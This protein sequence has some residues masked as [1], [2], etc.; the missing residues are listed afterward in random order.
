MD[1]HEE[2][3]RRARQG[4]AAAAERLASSG[5]GD[6]L[7]ALVGKR[8][9]RRAATVTGVSA[10]C[11]A[12]AVGGFAIAGPWSPGPVEPAAVTST[13]TTVIDASTP[14]ADAPFSF[15]RYAE[16]APLA[17]GE[18][19]AVPSGATRQVDDASRW[20]LTVTASAAVTGSDAGAL[21]L[22]ED[23]LTWT[24]EVAP[25]DAVED[26]AF[27]A[28][29][30]VE[31]DGRVAASTPLG[32]QEPAGGG[33]LDQLDAPV[34]GL[35]GGI[36]AN[37][38]PDDGDYTFHLWVQ[39]VDAKGAP[40]ATV[41]DPVEP[42][43]LN[44]KGIADYWNKSTAFNGYPNLSVNPIRCGDPSSAEGRLWND[45]GYSADLP[46]GVS[47]PGWSASLDGGEA[48][49]VTNTLDAPLT[50]QESF[51]IAQAFGVVDGVVV[52]VGD[53]RATSDALNY[54]ASLDLSVPC[55]VSAPSSMDVYV[56]QEALIADGSYAP[57]VTAA[58]LF[59]LGPTDVVPAVDPAPT[60]TD[61]P[62]YLADTAPAYGDAWVAE[63]SFSVHS[64][65]AMGVIT[66]LSLEPAASGDGWDV[67]LA[68]P[69]QVGPDVGWLTASYAVA[70]G[71][72]VGVSDL[73]FWNG[74]GFDEGFIPAPDCSACAVGAAGAVTQHVVIQAVTL[75]DSDAPL[76]PL[77]T[78]VDPFGS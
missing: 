56:L 74:H 20:P 23:L 75:S 78:W 38:Y 25:R 76:L 32:G 50:P 57:P 16:K 64:E 2:L 1:L 37:T 29:A 40:V 28:Y 63:P 43:T 9:R 44:V 3:A 17:C 39:V 35:C 49:R 5:A 26:L 31:H 55:G 71:K 30:V 61:Y 10:A 69:D 21:G 77:A 73:I 24:A 59:R 36:V 11:V 47:M 68:A 62:F 60:V 45:A 7:V 22:G 70:D 4:S 13:G 53:V 27:T 18:D 67:A 54:S 41:I 58:V 12:A 48:P 65:D 15:P 14:Q 72:V 6:A 51:A 8:R 52:A 46:V 42:V 33:V 66:Q 19:Y 34:P